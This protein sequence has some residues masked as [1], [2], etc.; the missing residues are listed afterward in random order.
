MSRKCNSETHD[1]KRTSEYVRT[2]L[3][4]ARGA[5]LSSSDSYSKAAILRLQSRDQPSRRNAAQSTAT[6]RSVAN[7]CPRTNG[8]AWQLPY[9]TNYG[10]GS[11][12]YDVIDHVR[13]LLRRRRFFL[14]LRLLRD[15]SSA[16]PILL[17]IL[18][19]LASP[20]FARALFVG[21]ETRC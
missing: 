20:D 15:R 19:T 7:V 17:R 16:L 14:M 6:K 2:P 5:P 18:H 10:L 12:S 11:S 4:E 1:V 9:N 8:Q 3:S 13:T 21:G